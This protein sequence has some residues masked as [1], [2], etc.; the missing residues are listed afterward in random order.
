MAKQ[1]EHC[2]PAQIRENKHE[3]NDF[4]NCDLGL[5]IV[6]VL[7]FWAH[8]NREEE[9]VQNHCEGDCQQEVLDRSV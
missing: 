9:T 6:K 5:D 3:G 4:E 1:T 7:Q 8:Q 2:T